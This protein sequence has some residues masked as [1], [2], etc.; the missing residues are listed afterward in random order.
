M[1]FNRDPQQL[2]FFL[3]HILTY[4][5]VYRRTLPSEDARVR[6]VTLALEGAAAC[7]MVTLHNSDA[8]ELRKFNR[9]MLAL[10]QHFEDHLANQKA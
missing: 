2:G 8:P 5:Q 6:I 4:M 10:R 9:F 7:W 3:G 1:K